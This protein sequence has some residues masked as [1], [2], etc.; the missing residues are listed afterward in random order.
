MDPQPP[1]EESDDLDASVASDSPHVP[2]VATA[3][4]PPFSYPKANPIA[5]LIHRLGLEAF[6]FS[7][8]IHAVFGMCAV[9][10]LYQWIIPHEEKI[11]FLPGGG[12]GER[13]AGVAE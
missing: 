7:V 5:R 9:L 4:T 13:R 10:V 8:F 2:E 11:D 6:L 3:P 1:D 12:G